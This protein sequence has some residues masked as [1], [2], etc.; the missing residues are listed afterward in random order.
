MTKHAIKF[1]YHIYLSYIYPVE[2]LSIN[3]KIK[4]MVLQDLKVGDKFQMDGL[5]V[6]GKTTKVKCEL[7]Q[8]GGMNKYVVSCQ[9]IT[10][11]VDGDSKVY[12]VIK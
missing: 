6:S 7:I 2:Q 1:G 5:S 3:V 12:N 10:I 8:Y 11:L 9:G 4:V